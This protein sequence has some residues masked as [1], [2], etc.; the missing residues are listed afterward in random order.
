MSVYED[1]LFYSKPLKNTYKK[2]EAADIIYRIEF[3]ELSKSVPD[4]HA[5]MSA[6]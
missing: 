1:T 5:S 2:C 6:L 4:R 3:S